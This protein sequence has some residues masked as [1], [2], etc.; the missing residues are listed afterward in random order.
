MYI[1]L[2]VS[3]YRI[4]KK[5]QYPVII[6]FICTERPKIPCN[7]LDCGGLEPNLPYLWGVPVFNIIIIIYIIEAIYLSDS[8][9]ASCFTDL[10][11]ISLQLPLRW[12]PLTT[13]LRLG[14]VRNLTKVAQIVNVRARIGID[15]D[16]KAHGAQHR[17][18]LLLS[19]RPFQRTTQ[20]S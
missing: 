10:V 17:A 14:E 9:H 12:F 5:P 11:S 13:K 8:L 15:P 2:K 4:L 20:A 3:C 18:L 16:L 7:S 1:F 19:R 6:T